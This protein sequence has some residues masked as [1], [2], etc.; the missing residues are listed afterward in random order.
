MLALESGS[1]DYVI[2][3]FGAR[4]LLACARVAPR[5]S[6]QHPDHIGMNPFTMGIRHQL[7]APRNAVRESRVSFSGAVHAS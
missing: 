6:V 4:E 3:P 1:D 5:H 2:E 7:R